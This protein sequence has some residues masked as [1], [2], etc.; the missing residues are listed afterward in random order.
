[1]P[2]SNP[3]LGGDFLVRPAMMSPNYVAG[4]SGWRIAKDGSVEF[5]N[6]VFRSSVQ[7]GPS[8]GAHIIMDATTDTILVYNSSNQIIAS[9]SP[10]NQVIGGVTIPQGITTYNPALPKINIRT[11]GNQLQLT[12]QNT[13]PTATPGVVAVNNQSANGGQAVLGLVSGSI[14]GNTTSAIQIASESG[15]ATLSAWIQLTQQ[16]GGPGASLS[17]QAVQTDG[18][19]AGQPFIVHTFS[20]SGTTD[21]AGRL[22]IATGVSFN[23]VNA[24][25]MYDQSGRGSGPFCSAVFNINSPQGN[26]GTQWFQG[27]ATLNN[28]LVFYNITLIGN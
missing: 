11:V 6:G 14:G 27:A 26:V 21:G 7:V 12:D 19:S 8:P 17:G 13:T 20:G 2:F 22:F 24:W 5:N 28:T 18:I 1:M 10:T 23:I 4:V 3:I 16:L 9:I 25:C 15:A